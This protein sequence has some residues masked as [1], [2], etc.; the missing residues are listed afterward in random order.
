M[1]KVLLIG[2]GAREHAMGWKLSQSSKVTKLIVAPGNDGYPKEWER[3]PTSLAPSEFENLAD[4][5]KEAGVDLV[6]VG[7]DNPLADGIVDV[8][9][10]R[11]ILIFGPSKKA[12]Q[13]EASKSFA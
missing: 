1:S 12:T 11:K 7:P 9:L 3:W 13:I 2:S 10:S 8:F 4:R 5:A 6:V